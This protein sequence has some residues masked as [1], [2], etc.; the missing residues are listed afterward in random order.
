MLVHPSRRAGGDEGL[1]I[2]KLVIVLRGRQGDEDYGHPHR[3]EFGERRR[4]AAADDE[5]GG[6]EG[7]LQFAQKRAHHE[8]WAAAQLSVRRADRFEIG[9]TAR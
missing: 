4:S 3:G 1:G 9:F 2:V 7:K 6:A 8:M 5:G